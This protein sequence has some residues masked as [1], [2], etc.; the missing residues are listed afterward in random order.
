MTKLILPEIERAKVYKE[1][2][3][4]AGGFCR[5][6]LNYPAE[7][8][9]L[10]VEHKNGNLKDCTLENLLVMCETC[11]R[12]YTGKPVQK[13]TKPKYKQLPMFSEH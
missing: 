6:C 7:G 3:R 4:I 1:A 8:N 11:R 2:I 10:T 5:V 12:D 13:K 9:E